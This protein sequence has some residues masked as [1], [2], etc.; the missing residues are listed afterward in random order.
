LVGGIVLLNSLIFLIK[1]TM[2]AISFIKGQFYKLKAR[3]Q[4]RFK[5]EKKYASEKVTLEEQKTTN[6]EKTTS[7]QQ[8]KSFV[9][10]FNLPKRVSGFQR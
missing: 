3:W 4:A 5:K 7:M 2:T 6:F 10:G 8:Y 9:P 1:F